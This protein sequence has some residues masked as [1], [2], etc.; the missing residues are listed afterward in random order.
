MFLKLL[1]I[2][3]FR[4]FKSLEVENLKKVNLLVGKNGSGKSSLLDAVFLLIGGK[5]PRL[6]VIVQNFR[7]MSI[8]TDDNFKY[9]FRDFEIDGSIRIVAET[10][11]NKRM[12]LDIKANIGIPV[13]SSSMLPHNEALDFRSNIAETSQSDKLAGMHYKYV[14]TNGKVFKCDFSI[15]YPL[16]SL[17]KVD[18]K[19][20]YLNNS[21]IRSM[22]GIC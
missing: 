17:P 2:E 9:L 14:D 18:V 20:L 10:F 21:S 12:E 4:G 19:G 15:L 22:V 6:T 7:A 8:V 5:N 13:V 1:H 3:N 16:P 11:D